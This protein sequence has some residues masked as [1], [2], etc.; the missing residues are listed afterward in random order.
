VKL[1]FG[2]IDSLLIALAFVATYQ[3][4]VALQTSFHFLF[5]IEFPIAALLLFVS[6]LC[7]L[8]IG[9]GST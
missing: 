3:T 1:V 6:I 9:Y 2:L 4:R 7:W 8:A 5:Y